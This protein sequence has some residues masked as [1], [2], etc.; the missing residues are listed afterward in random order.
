MIIPEASRARHFDLSEI[1]NI[2]NWRAV[3]IIDFLC[4]IQSLY[5]NLG[6]VG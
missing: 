5:V 1:I 6:S 4:R 2:H 3:S